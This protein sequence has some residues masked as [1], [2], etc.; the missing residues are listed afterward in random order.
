MNQEKFSKRTAWNSS[1]KIANGIHLTNIMQNV[2]FYKYTSKILL[3]I[4]RNKNRNFVKKLYD[5]KISSTILHNLKLNCNRY[6]L[7]LQVVNVL[8]IMTPISPHLIISDLIGMVIALMSYRKRAV[9]FVQSHL[10]IV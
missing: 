1:V 7:F 3:S 8:P 4:L 2:S 6:G 10:S 9:I 5:K